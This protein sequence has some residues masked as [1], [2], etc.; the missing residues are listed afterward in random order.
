MTTAL[1]ATF[2]RST[3]ESSDR[4]SHLSVFWFGQGAE[5]KAVAPFSLIQLLANN[6]N[7]V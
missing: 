3:V 7:A 6:A 2:E 1:S 5:D 4:P